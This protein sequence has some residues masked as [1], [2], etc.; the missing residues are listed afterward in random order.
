MVI[1]ARRTLLKFG[2]DEKWIRGVVALYSSASIKILLTG[3]KGPSFSISRSVRQGCPLA[4]YVFLFFAEA[5]SCYLNHQGTG[6]KG[7]QIPP[8]VQDL[9]DVEF[10]DDTRLYLRG[11]LENLVRTEL[12]INVFCQASGARINWHKIVGFWVGLQTGLQIQIS[13]RFPRAQLSA[14]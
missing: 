14:T 11:S 3:E 1:S 4:P 2:F 10:A 5:M 9:V 12:A 6:V 7:I 13:G 8:M